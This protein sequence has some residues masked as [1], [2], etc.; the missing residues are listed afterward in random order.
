MRFNTVV[1]TRYGSMIINR[2]DAYVGPCLTEYG[3]FSP[4]E[5]DLLKS[6]IKPSSIVL[7]VGANIGAVSVPLAKHCKTLLSFEPQPFLFHMLCG[8][9]AINSLVNVQAYQMAVGATA[10]N[11]PIPLI[12]PRIRNNFGGMDIRRDAPSKVNVPITTVDDLLLP[13]CDL[14]KCDVEGMEVEVLKGAVKTLER[15]RPAVYAENDREENK[16]ELDSLL[17]SSGR[18]LFNHNP[19][20]FREDNFAGLKMNIFPDYIV[21]YNLLAWPSEKPLPFEP[22]AFGLDEIP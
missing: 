18:R 11:I 1:S 19:P 6:L 22:S 4:D 12:D 16:A 9:I 14:I 5:L 13:S 8:N 10:G 3:E 7:D 21:S 2:L 15:C 17:K 20:L